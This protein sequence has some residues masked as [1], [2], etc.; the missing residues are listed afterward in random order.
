NKDDGNMSGS[1]P[2]PQTGIIRSGELQGNIYDGFTLD[3]N[4]IDN[5]KYCKTQKDENSQNETFIN[6]SKYENCN[7]IEI[8]KIQ[9]TDNE[10]N[11]LFVRYFR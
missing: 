9:I 1:N 7:Q 11:V 8:T 4:G 6:P 3:V 5:Y 10:G 2:T